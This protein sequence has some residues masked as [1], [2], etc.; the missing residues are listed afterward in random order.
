MGLGRPPKQMV[1]VRVKMQAHEWVASTQEALQRPDDDALPAAADD[2]SAYPPSPLAPRDAAAGRPAWEVVLPAIFEEVA[3]RPVLP[4][5]G[6][7]VGPAGAPPPPAQWGGGVWGE[8]GW[9]GPAEAAA[10]RVAAA[11]RWLLDGA[12]DSSDA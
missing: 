10:R 9:L 4:I 1:Q 5:P 3:R 7:A 8:G 2:D 11:M 6:A 12:R